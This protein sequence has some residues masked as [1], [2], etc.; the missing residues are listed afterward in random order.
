MVQEPASMYVSTASPKSVMAVSTQTASGW[1]WRLADVATIGPVRLTSSRANLLS[2]MRIPTFW[3]DEVTISGTS[4]CF[5]IMI[6]RGPGR[7]ALI[8]LSAFSLRTATLSSMALSETATERGM[9]KGLF[10][11]TYRFL[12]ADSL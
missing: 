10:L 12:T 2:G 5:L 9:S 1:E 4:G 11:T 8:S 3:E 6:V 7:K